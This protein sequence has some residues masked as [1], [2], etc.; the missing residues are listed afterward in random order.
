MIIII[1]L[2]ILA[3]LIGSIPSALIIGKTMNNGIDIREHGSGNLGTTNASRV[4]NKQN[5]AIIALFDVFIKGTL[6]ILVSNF[7]LRRYS[8]EVPGILFGY[9]SIIGHNYPIFAG[10]KGGKGMATTIGIIFAHG[11][12]TGLV[13]LVVLL[14]IITATGYVALASILTTA[15][16][17]IIGILFLDYPIYIE[18]IMALFALV[19]IFQHRSNIKRMFNK[20]EKVADMSKFF[21][22][23]GDMATFK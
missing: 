21:K 9:I 3:Y 22:W 11:F 6:V 7:I 19:M 10:F 12:F 2:G 20:T 14:S 15:I 18:I 13:A 16:F 8:I 23:L 1:T 17:T 5:T 4:L